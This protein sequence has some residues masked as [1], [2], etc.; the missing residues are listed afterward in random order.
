MK[1]APDRPRTAK[2]ARGSSR[3]G[4][5][6]EPEIGRIDGL[7]FDAIDLVHRPGAQRTIARTVE[8]PA[9]ADAPAAMWVP[10]GE[11][12]EVGGTLES[13]VEGIYAGGTARAHLVGECSRCLDPIEDD[14]EIRFDELFTYPEKVPRDISAEEREEIV[15]LDGDE[16]DL[17]PLVHDGLVLAVPAS[18]LCREDC[19]GLC[20]QCGARLEDD[21]DHHHDV[22]DDRFAAL[23]GLFGTEGADPAPEGR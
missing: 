8:A 3:P 9:L 19:A 4:A 18:P 13:V 21:P 17:G 12:V 10:A 15:V 11:P 20:A 14:V 22:I 1:N 16:V 5:T 2:P 6:S 23:Q 7:A